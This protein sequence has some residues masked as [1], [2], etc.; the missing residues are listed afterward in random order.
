[1]GEEE[2][3]SKILVGYL[4]SWANYRLGEGKFVVEDIDPNLCTHIVY[5]FAKLENNKITPFDPWLDLED[6]GGLGL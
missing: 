5:A 4:G 1:M 6:G 3:V 2:K